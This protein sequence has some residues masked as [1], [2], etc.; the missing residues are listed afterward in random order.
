[1][2]VGDV[3]AFRVTIQRQRAFGVVE[4]IWD[5]DDE[6]FVRIRSINEFGCNEEYRRLAN[7]VRTVDQL[8]GK[9]L[10]LYHAYVLGVTP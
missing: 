7:L 1:M 4:K 3:V 8:R 6:T 9:D 5:Q 10:T 2:K